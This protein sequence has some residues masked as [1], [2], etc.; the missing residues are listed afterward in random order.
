MNNI[1]N[2]LI[3]I[4]CHVDDFNKVLNRG[5]KLSMSVGIAVYNPEDPASVDELLSQADKS[6]YEQKKYKQ[7]F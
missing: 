5:Y 1:E 6:M 3:E 2:K 4:F 7:I